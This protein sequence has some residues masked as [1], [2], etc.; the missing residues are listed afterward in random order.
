MNNNADYKYLKLTN[1][2]KLLN[3]SFKY[4]ISNPL[5]YNKSY[6]L[7]CI[8]DFLKRNKT[9]I[10]IQD[11]DIYKRVTIKLYGKGV[12]VRDEIQGKEI[13]TKKQ[14]IVKA[15]QFILSRIDARNG[16]F[17]LVSEEC[18]NAIITNDFLAFDIDT[19]IIDPDFFV[20]LTTTKRFADY[21]QKSS[22]GTTNRQRISEDLFLKIKVPLPTIAQQKN[23]VEKYQKWNNIA[24]QKIIKIKE[25]ETSANK[26]LL[27]EMGIKTELLDINL[28]NTKK[29]IRYIRFKETSRWDSFY[30]NDAFSLIDKCLVSAK[31]PAVCIESI[32]KK[33]INGI[34]S[35]KY[36]KDGIP[37]L[38]V[39]NIR[40][41]ELLMDD[42]KY[43][44]P[45]KSNEKIKLKQGD[46]LITRKGTYG[47][48]IVV[49]KD[50]EKYLISSEVFK[51]ELNYIDY[52][53]NPYYIS[54][55]LNSPICKIQM[56]RVKTRGIMGSLSQNALNSLKIP[57][58][59]IEKQ[60]EI[61][62]K[63]KNIFNKIS[64]LKHKVDENLNIA[65]QEF[66]K[67]L[68]E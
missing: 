27:E 56:E 18:E 34:D 51:V 11:N 25:L 37:Y 38:R 53:L 45:A 58:A 40:P 9:P 20:L 33:I 41:G 6:G 14:F 31:F 8:G 10:D 60:D 49:E 21:C 13:G 16:A 15:G 42:I 32:Q 30:F 2:K 4:A 43:V 47:N 67:E 7:V 59:P 35:R 54:F 22:S 62:N 36:Q 12:L 23:I 29:G 28:E 3:W 19:N 48:S 57:L 52:D 1:Y 39:S 65:T 44:R 66:E 63:Y 55:M 26:Y 50:N 24:K 46:L 5:K 68:F 61:V 17:G 64:D